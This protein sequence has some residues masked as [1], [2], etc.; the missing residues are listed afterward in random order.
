MQDA[1]NPQVFSLALYGEYATEEEKYD[2]YLE[3]L[4]LNILDNWSTQDEVDETIPLEDVLTMVERSPDYFERL[5][6]GADV[7]D[8]FVE[9]I[10]SIKTKSRK[11]RLL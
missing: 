2:S 5:I 11:R 9:N 7:A 8:T 6:G 1:F 4:F 3:K 10:R